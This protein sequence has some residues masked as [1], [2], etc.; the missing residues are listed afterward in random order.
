MIVQTSEGGEFLI[1]AASSVSYVF[2][3]VGAA[4]CNGYVF[5]GFSNYSA[6]P[7]EMQRVFLI[8]PVRG[9]EAY[10][11][12]LRL[13][14]GSRS[15]ASFTVEFRTSAL[16]RRVEARRPLRGFTGGGAL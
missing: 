8:I 2:A 1:S 6:S 15:V 4:G 9:R 16:M 11:A 3:Q 13:R 10:Q 12:F 5:R 7:N 14:Q